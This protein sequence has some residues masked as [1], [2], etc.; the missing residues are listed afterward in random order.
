MS[1]IILKGKDV[2]AFYNTKTFGFT[3]MSWG[4][5]EQS[6][7]GRFDNLSDLELDVALR[8]NSGTFEL[9]KGE[10]TNWIYCNTCCRLEEMD[11]PHYPKG[12]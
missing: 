4:T 9:T 10:L 6:L 2:W 5:P 11:S 3:I 7:V 12:E 8:L 1:Q